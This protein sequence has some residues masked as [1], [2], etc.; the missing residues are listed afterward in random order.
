MANTERIPGRAGTES[1]AS[2]LRG[3]LHDGVRLLRV[4]L[5]LLGVE[6]RQHALDLLSL[7]L[8]GLLAVLLLGA[9]LVFLSALLTVLW[10]DS[11]RELVLSL[12]TAM[13]LSLGGVALW[14]A[15][16]LW[17]NTTAWFEASLAELRHDEERL[18]P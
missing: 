12:L 4:R 16:R 18:Q 2:G 10:W 11:H 6:A 1:V 5:D 3:W 13:F 14:W 9:G 17:R 7:L 8:V 15:L